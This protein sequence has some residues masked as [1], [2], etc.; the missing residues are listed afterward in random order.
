MLLQARTDADVTSRR[1]ESRDRHRNG[2]HGDGDA[3]VAM[4]TTSVT[5]QERARLGLG[6]RLDELRL[7]N[8]DVR[9]RATGVDRTGDDDDDADDDDAVPVCVQLNSSTTPRG[10]SLQ[11]KPGSLPPLAF[12]QNG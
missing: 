2:S 6:D 11:P 10:V 7:N 3:A 12:R 9:L 4:A 1:R 8:H 5:R